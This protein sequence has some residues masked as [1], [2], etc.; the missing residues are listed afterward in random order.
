MAEASLLDPP[1]E[2]EEIEAGLAELHH[3]VSF[4]LEDLRVPAEVRAKVG[5]LGYGR[6]E[7]LSA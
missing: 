6:V 2:D 1:L 7:V 4:I 5:L 3:D